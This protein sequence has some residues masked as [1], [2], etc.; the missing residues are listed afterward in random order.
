MVRNFPDSV[1]DLDRLL[2]PVELLDQKIEE[3][4][5]YRI[6]EMGT[7]IPWRAAPS[8]SNC[9]LRRE[10]GQVQG[11]LFSKPTDKFSAGADPLCAEFVYT[12]RT[13]TEWCPQ[14]EDH[15]RT[16][17][18]KYFD[19]ITLHEIF[20]LFGFNHDY[21]IDPDLRDRGGV[22][23]SPSLTTVRLPEAEA[24]LWEDIDLLRCIF[25]EGG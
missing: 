22:E 24:V 14:C 20:H 5:G 12:R 10:R 9:T 21:E 18:G 3:Q 1:A 8:G 11:Y 7:L 15:P 17:D 25:P 2:Q 23:M 16:Q 4:L 6:V 13:M 19:A